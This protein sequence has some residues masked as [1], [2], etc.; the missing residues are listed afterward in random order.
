M[1]TSQLSLAE[2]LTV[3]FNSVAKM[4]RKPNY[5]AQEDLAGANVS[6]TIIPESSQPESA[7]EVGSRTVALKTNLNLSNVQKVAE[8]E[9]PIIEEGY[10]WKGR[11]GTV[12]KGGS[13][14]I[15]PNTN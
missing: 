5:S 7:A 12:G 9:T 11:R 14:G 15:H 8:K 2:Q 10:G 3:V 6:D 13:A 4:V 1:N